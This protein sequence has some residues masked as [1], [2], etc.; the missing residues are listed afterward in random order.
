MVSWRSVGGG[1]PGTSIGGASSVC[2]DT[3]AA[4]TVAAA[5]AAAALHRRPFRE[6]PLI[7]GRTSNQRSASRGG[8]AAR[9]LTCRVRF[10]GYPRALAGHGTPGAW[11]TDAAA[12]SAQ[13]AED[14]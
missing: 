14:P 7:S 10:V 8:G 6:R 12:S 3:G 2:S 9:V 1:P 4:G 5:L 11:P 13:R